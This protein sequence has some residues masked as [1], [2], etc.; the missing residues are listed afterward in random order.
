M[1]QLLFI[2]LQADGGSGGGQSPDGGFG[3]MQFVFFIG[4]LAVFYFFMIR[5]Q[6]KR[7]K[8]E[9]KFREGLE[10]GDKVMSIGGIYGTIESMDESTVLLKVDQNTKLRMDKTSLR[11]IPDS[12]E[13]AKS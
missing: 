10:K 6:Q 2:L 11:A 12:G 4:I 13:K 8:E 1:I 9:K 3:G 5:P 7:A